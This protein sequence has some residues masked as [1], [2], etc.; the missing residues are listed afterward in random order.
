LKYSPNEKLPSISK[1]VRWNV[2]R[3]TSSMSGVRKTFWTV[4]SSGAGGVSRPRKYGI[5]GCMPALL[6]SVEWSHSGGTR[7]PDG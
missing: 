4:A 3:P 7:E 6:S 2:S 5:S 1:N